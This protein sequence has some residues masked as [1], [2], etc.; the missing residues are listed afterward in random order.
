MLR[1]H[2]VFY[3]KV[4]LLAIGVA[5]VIGIALFSGSSGY[6]AENRVEDWVLS[7][8][9]TPLHI[10]V[11]DNITVEGTIKYVGSENFMAWVNAMFSPDISIWSQDG[12]N[13]DGTVHAGFSTELKITPQLSQGH[14]FVFR[15]IHT[16]GMYRVEVDDWGYNPDGSNV[17]LTVTLLIEV[18]P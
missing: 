18:K 15:P 11:N 2:V 17:K 12:T 10:T 9:I 6:E 4:A 14:Q 16:P 1:S 3:S 7:V 5:V 13:I 8:S